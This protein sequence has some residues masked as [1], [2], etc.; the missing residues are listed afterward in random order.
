MDAFR[1]H[2]SLARPQGAKAQRVLYSSALEALG[3]R[4]VAF[5]TLR[6]LGAV[7]APD[8]PTPPQI[9]IGIASRWSCRVPPNR[10]GRPAG[11]RHDWQE[12]TATTR[13]SPTTNQG[14]S[15]VPTM[16]RCACAGCR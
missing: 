14:L 12:S 11:A 1:K 4:F 8:T 10:I 9:R 6:V 3:P 2:F 15:F 13:Q 16:M 5:G 7:T